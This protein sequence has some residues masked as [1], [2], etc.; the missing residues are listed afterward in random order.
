MI[1]FDVMFGTGTASVARG[2]SSYID[3]LTNYTMR[4][5]FLSISPKWEVDFLSKYPDFFSFVV[6]MLL[7]GDLAIY[8]ERCG[9]G[10]FIVFCRQCCSPS[11]SKSRRWWTTFSRRSTS[12]RLPLSS[13]LEALKVNFQPDLAKI[14]VIKVCV[15]LI[16]FF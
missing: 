1:L 12:S 10:R 5:A 7:A 15:V 14:Y 8:L 11:E 16:A 3:A 13:S 4:D 9:N 2:M 6:V